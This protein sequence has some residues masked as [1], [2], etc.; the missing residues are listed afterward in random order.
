MYWCR[1]WTGKATTT[2]GKLR[3]YAG[4]KSY[5]RLYGRGMF[6]KGGPCSAVVSGTVNPNDLPNGGGGRVARDRGYRLQMEAIETPGKHLLRLIGHP[7]D[8]H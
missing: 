7:K 5:N 1:E 4:T 6:T 3:L 8:P 2:K